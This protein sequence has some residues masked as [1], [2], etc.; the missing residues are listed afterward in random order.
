MTTQVWAKLVKMAESQKLV[1]FSSHLKEKL[2]KSLSINF[3]YNMSVISFICLRIGRA[4]KY[5]LIFNHFYWHNI[6]N[7]WLYLGKKLNIIENILI[8]FRRDVSV[9]VKPEVKS[10]DGVNEE[11]NEEEI[12]KLQKLQ[13]VLVIIF[14]LKLF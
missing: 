6:T 2:T 3:F 12:L 8:I 7:T 14:H 9:E 1:S 5:P 11:E 13:D 4:W 10:E